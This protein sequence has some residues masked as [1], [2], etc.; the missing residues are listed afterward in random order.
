MDILVT[1]VG[2]L[3]V[4]GFL[5]ILAKLEEVRLATLTT[6]TDEARPK[7]LPSAKPQEV[8]NDNFNLSAQLMRTGGYDMPIS[9]KQATALVNASASNI[10]DSL[11]DSNLPVKA[12]KSS[13]A[14]ESEALL[15]FVDASR[16][17][18]AQEATVL[19]KPKS[20][21]AKPKRTKANKRAKSKKAKHV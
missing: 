14:L 4:L 5:Y 15:R 6:D 17:A 2:C 13:K 10:A 18:S 8:T 1:I 16:A 12:L 19:L 9:T 20:Q 11:D 3:F 21:R 7:I